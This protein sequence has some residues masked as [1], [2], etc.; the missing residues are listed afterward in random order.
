MLSEILKDSALAALPTERND[1]CVYQVHSKS[2]SGTMTCY[3]VLPGV[4]LLYN[5][6]HMSGFDSQFQTSSDLFCID[7]CREGRMEY[8]VGKDAFSYVEAGDL[9]LDR[10]LEHQ[11]SLIHI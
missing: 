9:K 6:F 2:G 3:K 7:Y 1:C 10:R 8:A 5:D 11:L 4:M